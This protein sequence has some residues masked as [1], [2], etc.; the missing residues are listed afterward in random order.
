MLKKPGKKIRNVLVKKKHKTFEL[1]TQNGTVKFLEITGTVFPGEKQY[2]S[3]ISLW[4]AQGITNR[5]KVFLF[6]YFNNILGINTRL[7]HF[8][9]NQSRGCTF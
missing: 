6:K 3:V 2:G 5:A 8:V 4:N 7:S 1:R 9:P